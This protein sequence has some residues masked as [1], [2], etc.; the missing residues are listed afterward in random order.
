MQ[1]HHLWKCE[2]FLKALVVNQGDPNGYLFKK[3]IFSMHSCLPESMPLHH[4]HSFLVSTKTRI[5]VISCSIRLTEWKLNVGL[6]QKQ[7]VLR[8]AEPLL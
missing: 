4:M 3:I 6:L 5:Q 1:H 8:S 2:D 7:C